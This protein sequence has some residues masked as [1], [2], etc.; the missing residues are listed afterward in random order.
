MFRF[1][2]FAA[3]VADDRH[4]AIGTRNCAEKLRHTLQHRENAIPNVQSMASGEKNEVRV[5]VERV[6][7]IPRGLFDVR[8]IATNM[9]R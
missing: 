8:A 4:C 6:A 5:E 3:I 2:P 9:A 1:A 7:V